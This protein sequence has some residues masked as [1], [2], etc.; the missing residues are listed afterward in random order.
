M[1]SRYANHV[2]SPEQFSILK[3]MERDFQ[4]S[5]TLNHNKSIKTKKTICI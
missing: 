3:T 2:T 1:H 5:L 4:K